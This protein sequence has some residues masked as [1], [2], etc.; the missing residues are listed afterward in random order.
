MKNDQDL[1]RAENK[2]PNWNGGV[3]SRDI[4]EEESTR[5]II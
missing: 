4:S 3:D 1:N 5:C 2:R